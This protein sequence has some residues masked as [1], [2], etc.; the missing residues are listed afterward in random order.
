MFMV[1]AVWCMLIKDFPTAEFRITIKFNVS[2]LNFIRITF[3]CILVC[4]CVSD[5]VPSLQ[6]IIPSSF[7]TLYGNTHHHKKLA[8]FSFTRNLL[9]N[10]TQ[11]IF[12]LFN[13]FSLSPIPYMPEIEAIFIDYFHEVNC[14]T[15][16]QSYV[17]VKKGSLLLLYIRGSLKPRNRNQGHYLMCILDVIHKCIV[18]LF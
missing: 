15:T 13:I 1:Y 16:N 3:M 9:L 12:V 4:A 8:S 6:S 14:L 18:Q 11:W 5:T 2:I 10:W 17:C 7:C